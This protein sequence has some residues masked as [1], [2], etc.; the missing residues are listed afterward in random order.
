MKHQ[1]RLIL[2]AGFFV[3]A[4]CSTVDTDE[5]GFATTTVGNGATFGLKSSDALKGYD[6]IYVK[7]VNALPVAGSP[8]HSDSDLA[9]LEYAFEGAFKNTVGSAMPIVDAPGPK[10]LA[11]EATI[12]EI[13]H[14]KRNFS[15]TANNPADRVNTY[16]AGATDEAGRPL[17]TV[18]GSTICMCR[19]HLTVKFYDSQ[20]SE[21]L[22]NFSDGGFGE[23]LAVD[24]NGQTN[25]SRV[26]EAMNQWCQDMKQALLA[27]TQ[28]G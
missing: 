8:Q 19:V 12:S 4:G 3:V 27:V 20:T 10:T 22:A 6:S 9:A 24:Q 18:A 11:V 5:H 23:E 13:M 14:A 26:A 16:G 2:L 1:L 17:A 7:S 28:E 21:L 15:P 25:W